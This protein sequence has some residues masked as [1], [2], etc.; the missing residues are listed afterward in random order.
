MLMKPLF[1][2][3]TALALCGL[4]VLAAGCGARTQAA[5]PATQQQDTAQMQNLGDLQDFSAPT[6]DGGTFDDSVL[7]QKDLTMVNFWSTTCPPCIKELPDLEAVRAGAP[8]KAQVILVCLDGAQNAQKAQAYLDK[9]GYQ[10]P[11]AVMGTGGM[12]EV[13]G[14]MQYTPTTLFFDKNGK[15]VGQALIGAP[16]DAQA[17]YSGLIDQYLQE[18]T[19]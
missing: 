14:R 12:E 3:W 4:L 15:A 7:A 16:R 11:V 1:K 19:S 17:A 8:D 10:G 18:A 5:A 2:K 6:L 9:A 13:V